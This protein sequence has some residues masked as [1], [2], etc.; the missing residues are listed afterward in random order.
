MNKK[1][2]IILKISG[3]DFKGRTIYS[4][5]TSNTRYTPQKVRAAVFSILNSY[6]DFQK[7]IFLDMCSGSGMMMFEALSRGIPNAEAVEIS[8]KAI[9]TIKENIDLLGVSEK[10]KL[11]KID[12][13]RYIKKTDNVYNILFLDPPFNESISEKIY[14]NLDENTDII[15]EDGVVIIEKPV[16]P[17]SYTHLTLPTN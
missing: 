6:V 13:S 4:V 17:V 1:N 12:I 14:V 5:N 7:S 9:A 8:P 3:G 16:K 10:I 11:F 2:D 15:A